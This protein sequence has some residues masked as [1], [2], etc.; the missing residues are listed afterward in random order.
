MAELLLL[1][2]GALV[3]CCAREVA[4]D[5]H[6]V[7]WNST[8]KSFLWDD[9]TVKVSMNDYL[10]IVCPHYEEENLPGT[11]V[12]RYT[13]F[14]VEYEEY[15]TCKPVSKNQVRWECNNPFAPHGP[16]RFREKFQK[17]TAFSLG[18]EF[19]EGNSYYYISKPIHHHGDS[20]LKLKVDVAGKDGQP[21][22]P[23]VHNPA[24][25]VLSDEPAEA[26]PN[27]LKSVGSSSSGGPASFTVF[28]LL[29]P[30]LLA[31]GL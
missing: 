8:N 11:L 24:G 13:L 22:T 29:L 16:E 10:D 6:T 19:K 3:L 12:E 27:I 23:N 26:A 1:V 21:A 9:Y 2:F 20:C 31:I 28:G 14:L 30:L 4:A 18:K 7:Y 25:R 17:F 5:V 15:T